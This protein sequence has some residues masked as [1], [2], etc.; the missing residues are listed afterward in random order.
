MSP[1][2][3]N[4]RAVLAK[5]QETIETLE[6]KIWLAENHSDG[7]QGAVIVEA[8][9]LKAVAVAEAT[10]LLEARHAWRERLRALACRKRRQPFIPRPR[11]PSPEELAET[12]TGQ[13][14]APPEAV[15]F[16]RTALSRRPFEFWP[17][18]E[19]DTFNWIDFPEQQQE[20]V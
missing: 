12:L 7:P 10:E 19:D 1:L 2:G 9:A 11:H 3:E 13:F 18:P 16:Y 8:E 6:L 5:H 20:N 14:P 17:R 15:A 4:F